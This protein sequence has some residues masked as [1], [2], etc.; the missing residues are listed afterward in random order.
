M[1][2]HATSETANAKLFRKKRSGLRQIE[3][4]EDTVCH[5]PEHNPP[6]LIALQPGEYKYTCPVCGK[7]TTFSVPLISC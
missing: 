7:T 2:Y 4:F 1:N 6:S 3:K 5:D